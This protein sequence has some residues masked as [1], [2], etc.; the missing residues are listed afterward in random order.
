MID[1]LFLVGEFVWSS[2]K[3]GRSARTVHRNSIDGINNKA[4]ENIRNQ[5]APYLIRALETRL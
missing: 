3:S 1:G 4:M 2:V 5:L